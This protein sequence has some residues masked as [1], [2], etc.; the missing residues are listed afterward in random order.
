M[1]K[2]IMALALSMML[3]NPTQISYGEETKE[4]L[5]QKLEANEKEQKRLDLEITNVRESI[6]EVEGNIN[7]TNQKISDLNSQIED[8]KFKREELIKEINKNKELLGERLKVIEKNQSMGY[9][10]VILSSDSISE[11]FDNI[12]MVKQIVE[13]DKNILKNLDDNK[14]KLEENTKEVEAKKE[15]T[16]NLKLSLEEDNK[17]LNEKKSE[18]EELKKKLEKE[19]DDL[20][21]EI[22]KLSAQVMLSDGEIAIISSGSWP[23]PSSTRITSPYG[24]RIHPIFNT[25]KMHTGIDI[26][27]PTGTPMVAIDNGTVIFSGTKGGYGNTVMIKHDDGKVTLY[28]HNSQNI[29]SNGQRV[30][31][32]QIVAKMG[33][34][35]NSTGPHLH[36][37]VRINGKHVN[38]MSYIK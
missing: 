14:I 31:K 7:L 12:Y 35:G 24:Y 23:V 4:E 20:E 19:E 11:F 3:I 28:G 5:E 37:E 32:G 10:S 16:N 26:A 30:S 25:R 27:A 29:V 22:E 1:N 17:R 18:I 36:F 6:R 13:N 34:T 21:K 8:L 38:P 2:K 15:E 33:S 9:I